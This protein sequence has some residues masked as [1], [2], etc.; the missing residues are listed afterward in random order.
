MDLKHALEITSDVLGGIS[1]LVLLFPAYRIAR[2][3]SLLHE[4][5]MQ[6]SQQAAD[7]QEEMGKLLARVDSMLDSFEPADVWT[8]KAGLWTLVSSFVIKLITHGM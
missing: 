4:R 3:R 7:V 2:A 5:R 1:G 6:L 8:L